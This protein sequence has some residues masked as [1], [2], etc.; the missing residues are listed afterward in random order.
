MGSDDYNSDLG[1]RDAIDT[2]LG[3][4]RLAATNGVFLGLTV[5][6]GFVYVA[7][8]PPARLR[9][10]VFSLHMVSFALVT[11]YLITNLAFGPLD[12]HDAL[13]RGFGTSVDH[14]NDVAMARSE[15]V[16]SEQNAS[17]G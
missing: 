5:C 10:I 9:S 6:L 15:S 2:L 17:E 8:S 4:Y 1:E 3:D 7:I 14:G 11:A 13:A 16:C 12:M